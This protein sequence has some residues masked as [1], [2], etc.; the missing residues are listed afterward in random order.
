MA[1]CKRCRE[2]HKPGPCGQGKVL[3]LDCG[4]GLLAPERYRFNGVYPLCKND[5]ERIR[6]FNANKEE[7]NEDRENA[8][9]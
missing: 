3:C 8:V 1:V 4:M 5:Y 6:D 2:S 7:K 9:P